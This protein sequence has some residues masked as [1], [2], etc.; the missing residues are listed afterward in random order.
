MNQKYK[1]Y[2][3][4]VGCF[5]MNAKKSREI[6]FKYVYIW[7]LY[8]KHRNIYEHTG[9]KDYLEELE[10]SVMITS[11]YKPYFIVGVNKAWENM[12]NISSKVAIGNSPPQIFDKLNRMKN[13]KSSIVLMNDLKD[14]EFKDGSVYKF[15]N[16]GCINSFQIHKIGDNMLLNVCNISRNVCCQT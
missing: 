4:S 2:Y 8:K 9:M 14:K 15:L 10:M 11:E 16:D 7:Y 1:I 13:H 3:K 5:N 6:I 12:F